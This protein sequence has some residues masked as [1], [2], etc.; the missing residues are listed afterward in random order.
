[1]TTSARRSKILIWN[2]SRMMGH[3]CPKQDP[4]H[5]QGVAACCCQADQQ[6]LAWDPA[7]AGYLRVR[8]ES[9]NRNRLAFFFLVLWEICSWKHVDDKRRVSAECLNRNAWK[10]NMELSSEMKKKSGKEL[11]IGRQK[12]PIVSAYNFFLRSWYF[13]FTMNNKITV[14]NTQWIVFATVHL[15]FINSRAKSRN[16]R[17][18]ILGHHALCSAD[19]RNNRQP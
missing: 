9:V 19:V 12:I 4:S 2:Q 18:V 8:E 11:Q 17:M 7:P 15:S 14:Q 5:M 16:I 1:M 13:L 3:S 10:T 6:D